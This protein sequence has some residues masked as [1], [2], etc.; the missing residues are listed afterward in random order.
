MDC[1]SSSRRSKTRCSVSWRSCAFFSWKPIAEASCWCGTSTNLCNPRGH[2]YFQMFTDTRR[3]YLHKQVKPVKFPMF[4][5]TCKSSSDMRMMLLRS[6]LSCWARNHQGVSAPPEKSTTSGSILRES[7]AIQAVPP[8]TG[9]KRWISSNLQGGA[10]GTSP[11]SSHTYSCALEPT[12]LFRATT[13]T[14]CLEANTRNRFHRPRS[15][16]HPRGPLL[17]DRWRWNQETPI[18]C[19]ENKNVIRHFLVDFLSTVGCQ[20]NK[21][22]KTRITLFTLQQ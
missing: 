9:R 8:S 2:W 15:S 16:H 22:L 12:S 17:L 11:R 5:C 1:L 18:L 10:D 3:F 19:E 7:R 21:M 13:W 14:L 4:S 6:C 20:N